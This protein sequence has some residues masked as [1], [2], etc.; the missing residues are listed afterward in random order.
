MNRPGKYRGLQAMANERQIFTILAI[1]HGASLA[2]TIQPDSP[3]NVSYEQM[4]R[5]KQ[6]I[7]PQLAPWASG[8]LIDPTFGLA[9]AFLGGAVPGNVGTVMAV[10]DMDYASVAKEA[11]LADGWSVAQAK[12]AGANAIKCFFYYHP[13]DGALARHQ[14]NFVK[15]LVQACA[16]HDI[17]LFAEPLSYH[18]TSETRKAVVIETVRRVSRWGIDVLKI[19]FPIDVTTQSDEAEWVSACEEITAVC[20]TPWALLSAGVDFD[21]FARQVKVA[22]QAGASGYLAGRAI[23][24]EGVT[25]PGPKQHQFWQQ[26]ARPRLQKLAAIATKYGKPWTDFY[27]YLDDL[28]QKGWHKTIG[29]KR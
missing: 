28:P 25:L 21:M 13:E 1:D 10:E 15:E 24:K 9:P 12:H 22:C 3:E 6:T 27:P 19:E 11:R 17:P 14:E 26:V 29:N 4:V 16:A 7:L 20:Q 18:T 2:A 5:V 8:V 23:W